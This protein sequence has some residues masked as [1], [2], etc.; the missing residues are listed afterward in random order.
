MQKKVTI[1]I[2]E[3]VNARWNAVAK[4]LKMSKSSMVEEYLRQMLPILEQ[5]TPNKMIAEAMKE[6]AKSIDLSASLFEVPTY[7]ERAIYDKS[8]D[9]YKKEKGE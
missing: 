3:E 6:M 9:D 8:V 1:T 7:D 4:F 2:D 5:K